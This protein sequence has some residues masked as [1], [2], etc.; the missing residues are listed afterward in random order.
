MPKPTAGVVRPT[1]E[2]YGSVE[3]VHL[4]DRT[5]DGVAVRHRFSPPAYFGILCARSLM[6][7]GRVGKRSLKAWL[8]ITCVLGCVFIHAAEAQRC[9]GVTSMWARTSSAA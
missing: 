5:S 1:A 9:D 8:G 4:S 6:G 3:Y 7:K 2:S